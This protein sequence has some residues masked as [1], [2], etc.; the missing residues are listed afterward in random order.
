MRAGVE[1]MTTRDS[2]N[3]ITRLLDIQ[4][5]R[6]PTATPCPATDL[7]QSI[8]GGFLPK[9]ALQWFMR[10]ELASGTSISQQTLCSM[11]CILSPLSLVRKLSELK[12]IQT[13]F[14]IHIHVI[15]CET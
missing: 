15:S 3:G 12:S 6:D 7:Q 1:E 10:G 4:R 14:A 5:L 9:S 2:L 13:L 8:L 11:F